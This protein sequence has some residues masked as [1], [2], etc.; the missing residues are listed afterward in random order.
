MWWVSIFLYDFKF[1]EFIYLLSK[2]ISSKYIYQSFKFY[3]SL[4][5]YYVH[6][7]WSWSK[8]V[9][10]NQLRH[11]HHTDC[12]GQPPVSLQLG[13]AWRLEPGGFGH[14]GSSWTHHSKEDPS[15]PYCRPQG[16]IGYSL[17]FGV[18]WFIKGSCLDAIS[19]K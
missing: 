19:T 9:P 17:N 4:F 6:L 2:N 3:S 8:D 1:D 7:I 15:S 5:K 16:S 10:W 13:I 11:G 18:T 12:S 14:V